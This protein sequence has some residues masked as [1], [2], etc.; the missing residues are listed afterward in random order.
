MSEKLAYQHLRKGVL[1]KGDRLTRIEN[2]IG[3]GLPD[4]NGCF[5]GHEFWMV[6]LQFLLPLWAIATLVCTWRSAF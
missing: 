3:T 6:L 1:R 5:E 4:T 2:L